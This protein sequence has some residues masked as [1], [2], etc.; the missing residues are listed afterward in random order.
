M[1]HTYIIVN[2]II[3]LCTPEPHCI[4]PDH[5]HY[6]Y[7]REV[8]ENERDE[9]LSTYINPRK[10]VVIWARDQPAFRIDG[11]TIFYKDRQIEPFITTK[12]LDLLRAKKPVTRLH[13]FLDRLS[14]N[15]SHRVR[16]QLY[17]FMERGK[18]PI[19]EDGTILAYKK[20]RDDWTDCHTGEILHELNI[21]TSMNRADVDD[22]PAHACAPGLHVCSFDYLESFGG[23]ILIATEIDPADVVCIPHDHDCEKMRVC[24]HTPRFQIPLDIAEHIWENNPFPTE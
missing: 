8:L 10:A 1:K 18:M 19:Q 17:A 2:D 7:I 23:S 6:D 9:D 14:N 5:P 20:I 12:I 24:K 15:P 4:T 21:P 11:E 16:E 3:T 13:R 22:D